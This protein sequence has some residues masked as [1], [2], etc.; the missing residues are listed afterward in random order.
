MNLTM[1]KYVSY[2]QGCPRLDEAVGICF[3]TP[4][5][6]M[7]VVSE[8]IGFSPYAIG[9]MTIRVNTRNKETVVDAMNATLTMH[10]AE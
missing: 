2:R 5:K 8:F 10:V 9:A 6:S 3:D 1:Q 7:L 4:I